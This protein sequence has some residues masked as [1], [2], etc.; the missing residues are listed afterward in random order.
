MT[1]EQIVQI[2]IAAI[3][4]LLGGGGI[5]ALFGVLVTRKLGIR[6]TEN[7]AKRDMN[8][9]WDAIVEN[10]QNQINTQSANFT[11]QIKELHREIGELK[12]GYREIETQLGIKERLVLK[13]I[14][15]INRLEA[16]IISLGGKPASRP[17]G[18]E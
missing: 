9:T 2:A 18:L 16:I 4:A 13:A 15:H 17:E 6:T 11:E 7:E 1:T 3:A 14:S 10:L 5:A 12:T 8:N